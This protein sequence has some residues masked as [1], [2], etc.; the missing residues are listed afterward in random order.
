MSLKVSGD[1]LSLTVCHKII[2]EIKGSMDACA[3]SFPFFFHKMG[4]RVLN[5]Q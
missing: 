1:M 3:R 4:L 5:D 2:V